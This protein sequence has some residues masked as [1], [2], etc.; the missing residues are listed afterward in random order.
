M[1]DKP[2]LL[3]ADDSEHVRKEM[4]TILEDE[5]DLVQAEN[6]DQAWS[7]ISNDS[8]IK[9][10]F[11]DLT[12]PHSDGLSLLKRIR[13][14]QDE[15]IRTMPVVMMTDAHDNLNTVKESLASGVTDLVRKPFI[16]ELLRARANAN[17]KPRLDKQFVVT[18]TVDP[19][20]Q[21]ANEPYFM[22]R[23]ANNLSYAIRHNSGFG[24]LMVSIDRF[25][26]LNKDYEPYVMESVQVKVGT[27]INSVVRSE[28]TV[29]RLDSGIYGVL[30]LGVDPRGVLET[31][32]RIQQKV[33]KKAFRYNDK[34][35][36]ITISIGA[37]APVLKPYSSFE[38]IL[39]QARSELGN[40]INLGGDQIEAANIYQRLGGDE[41]GSYVPT[42]DEALEMLGNNQGQLL[43]HCVDELFS[44]L[45]P[46]LMYCDEKMQLNL[47]TQI[48]ERLQSRSG[49]TI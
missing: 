41:A 37:A 36:S 46:L 3:I 33:K 8:N 22:L 44:K 17:I 47:I 24:V 9:M 2:R 5:Y 38:M 49:E 20:T 16:P 43:G 42:L 48:K 25:E 32:S 26:E 29:A 21:L 6:G 30:L 35:F 40:A 4:L 1:S 23:G 13:S 11:T 39:R 18:A 7:M 10:V 27:Y 19:L 15:K 34:R 45:L 31:A 12:M 28:D 14:D